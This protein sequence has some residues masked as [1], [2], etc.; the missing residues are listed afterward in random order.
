[1]RHGPGEKTVR[2]VLIPILAAFVLLA[3]PAAA[4]AAAPLTA[5]RMNNP[6]LDITAT[7]PRPLLSVYNAS[8][9]EGPR[10]YDFELSSDPA[11]PPGKTQQYLNIPE[12]TPYITEVRVSEQNA[13]KGGRWH[14]RVRA[15]DAGRE[16]PWAVTRFFL[17]TVNTRHFCGLRRRPVQAVM[18]SSGQYAGNITD[19]DDP[20]QLTYWLSAPP[21]PGGKSEWVVFDLGTPVIVSRFWILSNPD[22]PAGRLTS[23]AW[24]YMDYAGKWTDIPG[25]SVSNNDTFRNV[26][27]IPATEAR[28]FRL[29]IRDFVGLQ[30]QINCIIP[31]G[32]GL[33]PLP[34]P[35]VGDYVLIIGDQMNGFTYTKVSDFV[36]SLHMGLDVLPVK[37]MDAS[38]AMI[39][40]LSSPP[41]AI[42]VSGNNADYPNMPM[43]EYYG[44]FDIIRNTE[45]PLLGICAGHQ[46]TSMAYGITFARGMGWFDDTTTRLELAPTQGPG[47]DAK[48]RGIDEKTGAEPIRILA[49]FEGLPIF[50]GMENPFQATE[51][52]SWAVSPR[53]LPPGHEVTAESSYVQTVRARDRHLYGAQFHG[54]AVLAYNQG[55]R[56][57]RNFLAIAKE[58]E[59]ARMR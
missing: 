26:M 15:R 50:R 6:S 16:G 27:D 18:A 54:E 41:T 9:G 56:Y 57:I 46:F 39:S 33:P 45:I 53:A 36:K 21:G 28:F 20:G 17:D 37:H 30:A 13:L 7:N 1:M 31:Y 2:S 58:V 4:P 5:P 8:G 22:G 10:T 34:I 55:G 24:Q 51:I 40:A 52:H 38:L 43:F 47:P 23:F 59:K 11:F 12:T 42:I 49:G 25:A 48:A 29:H 32:P 14:L 19:W 3:V 44:V 35:P